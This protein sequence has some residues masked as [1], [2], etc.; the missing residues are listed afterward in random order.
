M[1]K[2]NKIFIIL[3]L[4]L[5]LAGVGLFA[6]TRFYAV[7]A[8]RQ[9]AR[10]VTQLNDLLPQRAAAAAD[11]GGEMPVLSLDGRDVAALL[12]IP[13]HGVALPV[14]NEWSAWG[15]NAYPRRFSGSA[16]DRDL[17]IGGADRAGQLDCLRAIEVGTAVTVT[18]MTGGVFTYTVERVDRSK[19]A[20]AE[21]LTATDCALSLFVRDTYSLDYILVRCTAQ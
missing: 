10:M 17:V 21:R 8:R 20:E 2:R 16:Y 15:T 14:G 7:S 12:E 19:T 3:G 6:F 1:T 11:A 5:V 4:I 18:D 9:A 13:A